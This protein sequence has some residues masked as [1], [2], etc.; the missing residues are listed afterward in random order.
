MKKYVAGGILED[1]DSLLSVFWYTGKGFVGPE[2]TLDSPRVVLYGD[3]LQIDKDH[4]NVWNRYSRYTDTPNVEY[5]YYPR[6]RVLFNTALHKFVVVTDPKI[7]EDPRIREELLDWYH[8]PATTMFR[9]DE[10]YQSE[11]DV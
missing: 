8:L 2:D 3:Y 1:E 11:A 10:H 6:G 4:F 7:A 9:T 5:D